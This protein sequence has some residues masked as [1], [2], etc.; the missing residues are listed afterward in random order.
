M[1]KV[2][3]KTIP[4]YKDLVSFLTNNSEVKNVNLIRFFQLVNGPLLSVHFLHC[5]V[6]CAN[7]PL[8]YA[9]YEKCSLWTFLNKNTNYQI[10]SCFELYLIQ[11][12]PKEVKD[13]IYRIMFH[14]IKKH[15]SWD[16]SSQGLDYR[17]EEK[18]KII[19]QA[20]QTENPTIE[21]WCRAASNVENMETILQNSRNDYL[22][23]RE[24]SEP[25]SPQYEEKI[26]YCRSKI[27][28]S[29]F[30]DY[31]EKKPLT[32]L[33]DAALHKDNLIFE[34]KAIEMKKEYLE[35]IISSQSFVNA[36]LPTFNF[37][38]FTNVSE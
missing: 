1:W 17:M 20:L 18:N 5:S 12:A 10:I 29:E 31:D 23:M 6:R 33:D 25:Y 13:F 34:N 24:N 21:D 11:V 27:R 14:R 26:D 28:E 2:T 35:N 16:C 36:A 38:M 22:Y 30:L 9:A 19:K 37:Q 15:K 32:N 7:A 3:K 4:K 8:Y